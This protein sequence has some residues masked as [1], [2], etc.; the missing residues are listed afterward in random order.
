M[1]TQTYDTNLYIIN[2]VTH[3]MP[4]RCVLFDVDGVIIQ[5]P[6][7][8]EVYERRYGVASEKFEPFFRDEF[9]RCLV[10]EGDLTEMLKPWLPH[11]K[12]DGSVDAFLQFWFEAEQHIDEGIMSTVQAL[13]HEG[14]RCYLATNQERYRAAYLKDEMGFGEAF[15]GLYISSHIG[16]MKPDDAYFRHVHDDLKKTQGIAPHEIMFFDDAQR[17]VD[18]ALGW[19][20]HAYLYSSFEGF[21]RV[22]RPLLD[23]GQ[24]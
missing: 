3:D 2:G 22:I 6:L 16:A 19:G 8:S 15:D 23:H 14:I 17:N 20:I 11:W 18:A 21:E 13:R 1:V 9:H 7:F 5:S 4:I 10:D 24:N 12:W